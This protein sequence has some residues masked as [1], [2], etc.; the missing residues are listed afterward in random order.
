M[1]SAPRKLRQRDQNLAAGN[2]LDR[3]FDDVLIA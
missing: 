3:R 1:F 2:Y